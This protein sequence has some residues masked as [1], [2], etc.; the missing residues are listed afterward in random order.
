MIRKAFHDYMVLNNLTAQDVADRCDVPVGTIQNILSGK[1]ADPR[2][3][4]CVMI[5]RGLGISLD[6]LAGLQYAQKIID[7]PTPT[8]Q[9]PIMPPKLSVVEPASPAQ[10]DAMVALYERTIA[11]KDKVIKFLAT[12]LIAVAATLILLVIVFTLD[13]TAI[14]F[15]T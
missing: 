5:A 14:L 15:E 12:A 9:M 6:F 11:D 13:L 8:D 7:D 2:I 4:T 10:H 1:S 3:E